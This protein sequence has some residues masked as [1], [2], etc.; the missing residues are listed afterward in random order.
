MSAEVSH[1]YDYETD[2]PITEDIPF[3]VAIREIQKHSDRILKQ[4]QLA[5]MRKESMNGRNIEV[6]VPT[7][8]GNTAT[9]YLK[10]LGTGTHGIAYQL[11]I[12]DHLYVLKIIL[13][14]T[15]ERGDYLQEIETLKALKG[16]WFAL[17]LYA[18]LA[19]PTIDEE[20]DTVYNLFM[21]YPYIK[22]STLTDYIEDVGSYDEVRVKMNYI[23]DGLHELHQM[24]FSHRDLIG[25][26]IWIP[27]DPEIRPFFIDF[28]S[29]KRLNAKH[30]VGVNYE[31]LGQLVE[32]DVLRYSSDPTNLSKNLIRKLQEG[33]TTYNHIKNM[34]FGGRRKGVKTRKRKTQRRRRSYRK[35]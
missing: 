27:S 22:G 15:V 31:Q 2:Y 11:K 28:G 10:Q 25:D 19:L 26:N 1:R 29:A 9:V 32:H 8:S 12:N 6:P 16:K 33:N 20:G 13:H 35:Q 23:L 18:S 17:Q 21:L 30:T 34:K 3:H 14:M 5:Y 24:G 7:V 4:F